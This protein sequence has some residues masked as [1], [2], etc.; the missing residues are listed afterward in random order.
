MTDIYV[1]N[2]NFELQGIID[3]YVSMIWRPAYSEVGDFEIYLSASKK[4]IELLQ[5]N[6]YVVRSSDIEVINNVPVYKKVMVIKNIKLTTDVES[7]D[8]LTVTGRELKYILHSRIIW[9][10]TNLSETVENGLRR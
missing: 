10:Q 4:A 8:F 9:N 5:K 7:G 3:E 1:F 6:R 2:Q